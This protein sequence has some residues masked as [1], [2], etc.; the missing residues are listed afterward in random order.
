MAITIY[1]TGVYS[2]FINAQLFWFRLRRVRILEEENN[3][4]GAGYDLVKSYVEKSILSDTQQF[5]DV[6]RQGRPVREYVYSKIANISRNMV[7]SGQFHI[8]RGV[9]N[10]MGLGEEL[11]KIFDLAIDKLVILGDID[12]E[13]AQEQKELIRKNVL[14]VG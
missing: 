10:P 11:L 14:D 12:K 4:S 9:L 3:R 5:I 8:D 7:E 6:V 13:S 1:F 2:V